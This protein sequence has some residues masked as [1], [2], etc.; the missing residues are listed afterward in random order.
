MNG[1]KLR[2][3]YFESGLGHSDD[4]ALYFEVTTKGFAGER[5]LESRTASAVGNV[6]IDFELDCDGPC[7]F[8]MYEVN[9]RA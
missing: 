1:W 4:V 5:G 7:T 8:V 2:R 9:C 3:H 6:R